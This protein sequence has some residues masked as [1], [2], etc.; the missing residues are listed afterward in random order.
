MTTSGDEFFLPDD[1]YSF[2]SSLKQVTNNQALL[3]RIPNAEHLCIGHEFGIMEDLS[4]F[5]ISAYEV[6]F[7]FKVLLNKLIVI[8]KIK[9]ILNYLV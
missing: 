9:R 2:W 3:R 1:T 8:N 6:I 7:Q 5:Y 4:S